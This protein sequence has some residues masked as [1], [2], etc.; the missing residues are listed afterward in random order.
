MARSSWWLVDWMTCTLLHVATCDFDKCCEQLLKVSR[1]LVDLTVL[2]SAWSDN[3]MI[4]CGMFKE[5][6]E[7]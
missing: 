2:S 7:G 6:R 4:W 3:N 5:K 1:I